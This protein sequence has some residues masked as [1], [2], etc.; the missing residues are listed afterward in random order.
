MTIL[1]AF[2]TALRHHLKVALWLLAGMAAAAN[3]VAADGAAPAA[4]QGLP[5]FDIYQYV[6]GGNSVLSALAIELAVTPYLGERKTLRDVEGA[7]AALEKAYQKAGYLTVAVSI[8]EQA[9]DTG[10]VA[11]NVV[12]GEVD[13]LRVS[14]AEYTLPSSV[15]AAVP[16][17]AE[18]KVPNFPVLQAQVAALSRTADARVTPVLKAGVLPGTVEVQ[19]DVDDQLPLHGSVEVNNRQTPNTTATRL[20]TSLRYDNLWQRRHSVSL[21]LQAAP[22]RPSD[23]RVASLSYTLPVEPIGSVLSLYAVHSRSQFASLANAPGL[24]LLG[25]SDTAGLRLS[26]TFGAGTDMP[27]TVSAGLDYKDIAQTVKVRGGGSSDSPISYVPLVA[28][29]NG[30]LMAGERLSALDLTLTTGVRGLLGNTDARFSAKRVGASANFLSVRGGLAH[31]EPLG[32]WS[33]YAKLDVQQSTGPLVPTEQMVAGGADS[34]RGYLEGEMAGDI[35]LR[36]TLEL[37]TPRVALG[38]ASSDWRL[39]GLVFVDLARLRT[40]QA[41]APQPRFSSLGG[42]GLG[43][44]L[45]APAGLSLEADLARALVAGDATRSGDLRLHARALWAY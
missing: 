5:R 34:V 33:L 21:T 38:S 22:E 37:R 4:E 2:L 7:R 11:L 35:G 15:K 14:G 6:V 25:N 3:A 13:R 30:S 32:R 45:S 41:V 17:L 31:T 20:S 43:L 10:E 16:E 29:Y 42:A 26:S 9:V 39:G 18:G 23:A 40:L 1:D 12:E 8:P 19:L 24:G 44:R 28:S 27:Q 36:T